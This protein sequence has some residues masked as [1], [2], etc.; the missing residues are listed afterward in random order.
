M[1][2]WVSMDSWCYLRGDTCPA[3][4]QSADQGE[5]PPMASLADQGGDGVPHGQSCQAGS[6]HG[7]PRSGHGALSPQLALTGGHS[8]L[9]PS[10]RHLS[11][12][13]GLQGVHQ[14]SGGAYAPLVH[15][16]HITTVGK[17]A[18][19]CQALGLYIHLKP[20]PLSSRVP[21]LIAA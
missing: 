17:T 7:A 20:H 3:R 14:L 2:A 12:E 21:S 9:P 4:D 5:G 13:C 15:S 8:C 11:R 1:V 19:L 16:L 10:T 18:L 6:S